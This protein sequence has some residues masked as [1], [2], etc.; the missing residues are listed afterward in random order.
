MVREKGLKM[1]ENIRIKKFI[2]PKNVGKAA[3]Y[4]HGNFSNCNPSF[5]QHIEYFLQI[6]TFART[7]R[8]QKIYISSAA[9]DG[10]LC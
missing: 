9:I 8:L 6:R 4:K 3:K 10:R 7:N 2:V 1:E 5:I